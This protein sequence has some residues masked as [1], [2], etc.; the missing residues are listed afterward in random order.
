MTARLGGTLLAVA[1]VLF[2]L[3]GAVLFVFLTL[4]GATHPGRTGVVEQR[5]DVP[6][7]GTGRV[8]LPVK[9]G[10]KIELTLY[11]TLDGPYKDQEGA[12]RLPIEIRVRGAD[13]ALRA[14]F[15]GVW[16]SGMFRGDGDPNLVLGLGQSSLGFY[17]ATVT[18]KV[19]IETGLGPLAPSHA[20]VTHATLVV[21]QPGLSLLD[22][23]PWAAA[24]LGV[25][26]VV[27]G[28]LLRRRPAT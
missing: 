21:F 24:L 1:G 17:A 18:E 6:V 25:V 10:A 3:V 15:R 27:V 13:R 26:L 23:A 20:R 4:V 9:A 11:A 14:T 22:V 8:T 2:V 16:T 5:F 7:Q 28:L 19:V 12:L